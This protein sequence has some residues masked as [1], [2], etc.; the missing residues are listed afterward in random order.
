MYILHFYNHDYLHI[1]EQN[2]NELGL[3]FDNKFDQFYTDHMKQLHTNYLQ[4][5]LYP[6]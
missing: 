2:T 3:N 5:K 1:E 6:I 4:N